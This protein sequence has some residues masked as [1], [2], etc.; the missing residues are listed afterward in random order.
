MWTFASIKLV[1]SSASL[2]RR[3]SL[4]NRSRSSTHE[5]KQTFPPNLA[6]RHECGRAHE[7]DFVQLRR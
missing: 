6:G 3:D 7:R 4:Y 2:T 1:P 5:R